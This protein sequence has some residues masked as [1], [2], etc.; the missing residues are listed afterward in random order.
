MPCICF[1]IQDRVNGSEL[2]CSSTEY[3]IS[4]ELRQ[5]NVVGSNGYLVRNMTQTLM[6]DIYICVCIYLRAYA[7][8]LKCISFVVF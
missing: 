4:Y 7:F 3:L 8:L 2:W 5:Q 1:N 6:E